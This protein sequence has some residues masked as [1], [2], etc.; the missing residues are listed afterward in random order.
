MKFL[1]AGGGGCNEISLNGKF[2]ATPLE[3]NFPLEPLQ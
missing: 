1:Y 2:L 3:G